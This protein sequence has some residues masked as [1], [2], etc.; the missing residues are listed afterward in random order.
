MSEEKLLPCPFCGNKKVE[1]VM[2]SDDIVLPFSKDGHFRC[3]VLPFSKDRQFRCCVICSDC[4]TIGTI[5][6]APLPVTFYEIASLTEQVKAA[7]N[8]RAVPKHPT[9]KGGEE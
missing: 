5:I 8:R 6:E 3:T 2:L 7:W 1:A 9:A 4:K